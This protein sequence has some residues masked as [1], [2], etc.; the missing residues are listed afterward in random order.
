[1][2]KDYEAQ[3]SQGRERE[4]TLARDMEEQKR[5]AA[6]AIR[7]AEAQRA[8]SELALEE[9]AKQ[10]L[11]VERSKLADERKSAEDRWRDE[12]KRVEEKWQQRCSEEHDRGVRALMK[13]QNEENESYVMKVCALGPT[14]R[15]GTGGTSAL[16]RFAMSHPDHTDTAALS[17]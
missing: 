9:K 13:L 2:K 4:A 15:D 14:G 17:I 11:L 7:D 10:A 3:L 12:L 16:L 8:A 5:S 1:M 6:Q